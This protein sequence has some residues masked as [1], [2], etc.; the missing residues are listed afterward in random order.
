LSATL[1][2]YQPASILSTIEF[3]PGKSV[4]VACVHLRNAETDM[5][6]WTKDAF[7]NHGQNRQAR[8]FELARLLGAQQFLSRR[9]PAIVGGDFNAPA[10]DATFDLL[11]DRGF[12]DAFAAAGSGWPDTY[13]NTA[14]VLRI[15]HLWVNSGINPVRAAAVKTRH[16][17]H[18]MVVCDFLIP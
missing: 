8:R 11:N 3:R 4:E 1:T 2:G 14:P 6:L 18:R 15:D 13:P 7:R 17:D 12:A 9:N 10:G 16:S 5:K